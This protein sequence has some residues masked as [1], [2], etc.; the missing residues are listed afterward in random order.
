MPEQEEKKEEVKEEKPKTDDYVES[1]KSLKKELD[2]SFEKGEKQLEE[3]K[4]MYARQQLG[5]QTDAGE[6]PKT[7]VT[8]TPKEY[9]DRILRGE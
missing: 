1:I 6:Q 8:E 7:E 9:K 3:Y 2:E 5:G 4:A